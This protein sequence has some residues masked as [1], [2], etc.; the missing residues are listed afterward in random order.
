MF[1]GLVKIEC[2]RLIHY[3]CMPMPYASFDNVTAGQSSAKQPQHVVQ[4]VST[5]NNA[6]HVHQHH[7]RGCTSS[8]H[9]QSP[10]LQALLQ[11]NISQLLRV[12]K[13]KDA[14]RDQAGTKCCH[15]AAHC[16]AHSCSDAGSTAGNSV[17]SGTQL[18]AG[19]AL[20]L[21]AQQQK[22]CAAASDPCIQNV[23]CIAAKKSQQAGLKLYIL[24]K[25]RTSHIK[26][27]PALLHSSLPGL[28]ACTPSYAQPRKLF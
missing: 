11:P 15:Q 7:A 13:V 4:H 14:V 26:K 22:A 17:Q 21:Q 20:H 2:M 12:L 5:Q 23:A 10:Q 16:R 25:N 3:A 6:A 24:Y 28:P 19:V 8:T 18:L 1:S 27:V 9:L